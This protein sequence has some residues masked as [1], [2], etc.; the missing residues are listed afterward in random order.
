MSYRK[1]ILATVALTLIIGALGCWVLLTRPLPSKVRLS[2]IGY[3]TSSSGQTL[4]SFAFTNGSKYS[5]V[6]PDSC[7]I[8]FRGDNKFTNIHLRDIRLPPGYGE[9]I[10]VPPPG[11][12]RPW[13][14]G[15]SQYP[16]DPEN[17]FKIAYDGK[18]WVRRFIPLRL[19]GVQGPF[20]WS[21]WLANDEKAN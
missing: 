7:C 20:V 12:Q 6:A 13:R 5:V 9:I 16:E 3:S 8:Q 10:S 1:R 18:P 19:R 2:F 21:A 4:A 17:K 14:L 15:I 11:G